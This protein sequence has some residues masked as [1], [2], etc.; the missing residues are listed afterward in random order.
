MT[1]RVPLYLSL[2]VIASLVLAACGGGAPAATEE[3]AASGEKVE[4]R[5]WGHLLHPWRA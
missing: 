2:L 1:K 5:V 3:P 4:L